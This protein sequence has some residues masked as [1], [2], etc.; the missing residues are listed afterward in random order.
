VS[1]RRLG[2]T[3]LAAIALETI[4]AV[5]PFTGR[6]QMPSPARY[7]ATIVLWFVLGLAAQLGE[8]MARVAGQLATLI[9]LTMAV[10]GPFGKRAV[11]FLN[12]VATTFPAQQETPQ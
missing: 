9:V 8:R 3:L 10:L 6:S 2:A 11:D 5:D 12:R 4:G 7:V 1:E